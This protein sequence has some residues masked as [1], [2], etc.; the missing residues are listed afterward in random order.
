MA[1]VVDYF[2]PIQEQ[3]LQRMDSIL[4]YIS[5]SVVYLQLEVC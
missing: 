2:L 3:F 5:G 4:L 1:V